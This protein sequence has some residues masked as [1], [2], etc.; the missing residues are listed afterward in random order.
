MSLLETLSNLPKPEKPNL[1]L[2]YAGILQILPHRYPFLLVDQVLEITEG[3]TP[4]ITAVK[5]VSFNEP[6]FQGHFPAEPVMPGVL[7][8][9]AMAQAGG[10][11]TYLTNK[12][13]QGK[14]PAFMSIDECRF[15]Q[16]VRPGDRLILKVTLEK[17]RRGIAELRGEIYCDEK[18]VCNALMKATL[19]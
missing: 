10:I 3:E 13:T 7:Q 2:D 4:S 6:F 19:V 8:I 12:E 1:V 16:P 5:N 9:E 14:R 18:L 11:L 15:R 17:M